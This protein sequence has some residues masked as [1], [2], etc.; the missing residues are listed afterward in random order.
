[1]IKTLF[2]VE[3]GHGMGHIIRCLN[4]ARIFEKRYNSTSFFLTR[5]NY[6]VK[7]IHFNKE[8]LFPDLPAKIIA[9]KVNKFKPNIFIMDILDV[10]SN[11]LDQ[12]NK[13]MITV[14]IFDFFLNK[15]IAADVV[16]NPNINMVDYK[17]SS[18]EY[19]LG[20]KY[21]ILEDCFKKN[22]KTIKEKINS[23]MIS[24]GGSDPRNYT[25]RVIEAL[26]DFDLNIDV[27]VGPLLKNKE[28]LRKRISQF[29][30]FNLRLDITNKEICSLML[31]NDILLSTAG[32]TMYEAASIGLPNIV[33]CN[34]QRHNEIATPF[35]KLGIVINLETEPKIN[36]IK[37]AIHSLI[38]DFN[39]RKKMNRLGKKLIDGKGAERI[40]KVVFNKYKSKNL[41]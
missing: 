4:L 29:D 5:G 15:A 32:N 26:K 23:I 38:N 35:E 12:L 20:P 37:N 19:L 3:T 18:S 30:N 34:H 9:N 2:L 16:V 24:M 13:N 17:S 25:N 8:S 11:I 10:D 39:Q 41:T 31:K 40:T 22:K 28:D 36:T 27:V 1:M 14:A 6:G 33:F 7:K 21:V